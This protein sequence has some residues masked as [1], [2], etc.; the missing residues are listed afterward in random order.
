MAT[1]SKTDLTALIEQQEGPCVSIFMP[2]IREAVT[3]Q[4]D[5][6]RL[7]NLAR[8]AEDRLGQTGMRQPDAKQLLA[9]VYELVS[10][11]GFWEPQTGGLAVFRSPNEFHN[12]RLPL[13]FTDKVCVANRFDIKPLLPLFGPDGQFY[14]LAISQNDVR[15]L[16]G[17]RHSV[18]VMDLKGIPQ[19][20]AE[21]LKYDEAV[22]T[23]QFHTYS[24]TQGGRG[25]REAMF[26]GQGG[27]ADDAKADILQYFQQVDTGL[28]RMLAVDQSPLVFAGVE[29]LFPIYQEANG[30]P[31]LVDQPIAGN[32]DGKTNQELH[33]EAWKIVQPLFQQR[34]DQALDR[35]RSMAGAHSP[36][37]SDDIKEVVLGAANG[38]VDTLFVTLGAEQWGK[39]DPASNTVELHPQAQPGD[40]DLINLAAGQTYLNRGVVYAL[41]AGH[42]PSN[43]P[44]SAIFR[45]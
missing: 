25:G 1:L 36:K 42:S 10:L 44:L 43:Q 23:L 27:V 32:P 39:A 19:S 30:Y 4:Q 2:T 7:K 14:I 12:Y 21:A 28:R 16:K 15:L 18:N 8:Q 11:P 41:E 45:Y 37:A 38:R 9:P 33:V 20:R 40:D 24:P 17:T 29:Y 31:H 13:H 3:T 34:Q 6:I 5:P 26:H 22:K 35:Y